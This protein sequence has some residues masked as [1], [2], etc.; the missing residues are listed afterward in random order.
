MLSIHKPPVYLLN[1][2]V[3]DE[4]K[5]KVNRQE[6]VRNF[7]LKDRYGRRKLVKIE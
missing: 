4:S 5:N 3:K 1:Y 6:N 7:Y 2:S